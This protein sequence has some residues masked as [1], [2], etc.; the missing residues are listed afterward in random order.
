MKRCVIY[1]HGSGGS[2]TE[3]EHYKPLFA[4][5]DVIG[6]D[7]Q[8]QTPWEAKTEFT[9]FFAEIAAKYEQI[10]VVANSIG[11][12]FAMHALPDFKLFQAYFISPIVNMEHMIENML[13]WANVTEEKLRQ[14]GTITTEFGETLSWEYLSWVRA[15]PL[16]LNISPHILY[17]SNDN[18]QSLNDIRDFA[19]QTGA[20]V[21]VMPGGEHWF[22]T[23]EQMQFLDDWIMKSQKR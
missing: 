10:S 7:Y 11:A 22:H 3:A 15:H 23:P 12:F 14:K 6:F 20:D 9:D 13:Q 17:G 4:G 18:L 5:C 1:I 2:A 19:S 21:T 8:A 16:N